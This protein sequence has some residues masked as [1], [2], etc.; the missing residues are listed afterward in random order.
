[1]ADNQRI[2]T[3][4]IDWSVIKQTKDPRRAVRPA[5][6][7]VEGAGHRSA[8]PLRTVL[9]RADHPEVHEGP[10]L[11]HA[12]AVAAEGGRR[13]RHGDVPARSAART[14]PAS[15]SS[16]S[17]SGSTRTR[18][19][20]AT[21]SAISARSPRRRKKQY[22]DAEL[23]HQRARRRSSASSCRME[24]ALHGSWGKQV[25]EIDA[26]GGI[27]RELVD[28]HVDPVA[29]KDI[30]LTHR[31][32][33]AAVRR[34]GAGDQAAAAPHLPTD[35]LGQD[36]A[37]H[38][39]IDPKKPDGIERVYASSKEFG[40]QEWI[41][42]KAPAGSVVVEDNSNGQILA[43]ASYPRFDN[44]W[45][46]EHQRRQ[47]RPAVRREDRPST[48]K[49]DPDKSVLVNR[50]VQGRYN[51][52]STIKP[53]VAWSAMHSG[54]I[55]PNEPYLDQGVLQARV[56]SPRTSAPAACAA[57]SRTPP[58]C[59]RNDRRR[60]GRSRS[61]TLWRSVATRSSTASARSSG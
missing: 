56:D 29:G 1:M 53:F 13:R 7:A 14:S 58:T 45:M 5:V 32:R 25:F 52:G 17:G 42:Y 24:T 19:S 31:P 61:P 6:R 40:H 43:M 50:A 9:R 38:N 46:G 60:T 57:S 12:A 39:P 44:R 36:I 20:P 49:A 3:V 4:A 8:A 16:S 54:V 18:R 2:L 21:S 22:E 23:Q 35:I 55:G 34:A 37:A 11:Q 15:R 26:A 10:A 51:L 33:H 47:V 27:V 48:G 28:E 30:Q 59:A 41:Q